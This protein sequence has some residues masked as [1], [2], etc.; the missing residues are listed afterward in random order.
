MDGECRAAAGSKALDGAA[1]VFSKPTRSPPAALSFASSGRWCESAKNT[2]VA[3]TAAIAAVTRRW[4]CLVHGSRREHL[5]GGGRGVVR[6]GAARSGAEF[7]VVTY[8]A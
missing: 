6:S 8:F 1:P 5:G 7:N 4:R 2:L 3:Q